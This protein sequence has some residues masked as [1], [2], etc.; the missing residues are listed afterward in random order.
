[1]TKEWTYLPGMERDKDR[2]VCKQANDVV[3]GLVVGES[4]VSA[5]VSNHKHA[6]H[7]E[8]R[9]IPKYERGHSLLPE[10]HARPSG[11]VAQA[12]EGVC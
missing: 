9:N 12:I 11:R 1:M 2:T 6:P 3:K 7:E 8:T 5:V 4:G 10:R